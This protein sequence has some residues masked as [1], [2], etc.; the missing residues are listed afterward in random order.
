[1]EK[2]SATQQAINNIEFPSSEV[3]SPSKETNLSNNNYEFTN[4]CSPDLLQEK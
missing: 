2:G 1:M 4:D 3:T